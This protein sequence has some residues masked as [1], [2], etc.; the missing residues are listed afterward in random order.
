MIRALPH[1]LSR[2]FGPPLLIAP[3]PLDALLTGLHAAMLNRGSLLPEPQALQD[4]GTS[5]PVI[6][7]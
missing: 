4:N 2:V 1:I 5:P 7:S 3:V 6:A